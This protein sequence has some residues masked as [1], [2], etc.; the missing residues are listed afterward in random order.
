VQQIECPH[1][2]WCIFLDLRVKGLVWI[3]TFQRVACHTFLESSGDKIARPASTLVS[4]SSLL[5]LL[6]ISRSRLS[7]LSTLLFYHIRSP[8]ANWRLSLPPRFP[9]SAWEPE[10]F[11]IWAVSLQATCH[12]PTTFNASAFKAEVILYPFSS[13]R[14]NRGLRSEISSAC[15]VFTNTPIVP[16]IEMPIFRATFRACW[17]SR[18]ICNPC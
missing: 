4:M 15:L 2:W 1:F 18:I 8:S 16:I 11:I 12:S 6:F 9:G 17:S 5:A 10:L 14:S 13:N 3:E 7:V